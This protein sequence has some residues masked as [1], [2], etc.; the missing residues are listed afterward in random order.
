MSVR[1]LAVELDHFPCHR[2]AESVRED[3]RETIVDFLEVNAQGIPVG[4]LESRDLRVVI[5]PARLPRPGAERV[6]PD[7]LSLEQERVRR[8]VPRIEETL[9][10]IHVVLR[11]QL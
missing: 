11:R 8:A 1:V 4:S 7:D 2:A 6:E 9:D 3:V 10:G 5:E